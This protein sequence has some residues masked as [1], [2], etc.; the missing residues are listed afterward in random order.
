MNALMV[1]EFDIGISAEAWVL[2]DM[3]HTSHVG[4][5]P[6]NTEELAVT[7]A[8]SVINRLVERAMPV[9]LA[10]NGGPGHHPTAPT[11]VRRHQG[12]LMEALAQVRAEGN[13][14]LETIPV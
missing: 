3:D 1:K 9:G 5:N 11:A 6:D 7:I 10:T 13:T 2:L 12:R 8:S 4:E 14:T